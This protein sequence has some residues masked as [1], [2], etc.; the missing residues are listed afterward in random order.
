MGHR[1]LG[2][3]P[4]TR[5]WT[6]VVDLLKL[7]GDPSTI[8]S[9]T[10]KAAERGLQLTAQDSGVADVLYCLMTVVWAARRKDKF[11]KDVAQIG[12]DL[13]PTSSLLDVVAEF[14]HALD[15]RLRR[16]GHRTDLA[17]MARSAAVD[18]L[19]ETARYKAGSL[20][21][22]SLEDTRESLKSFATPS[23][24]GMIGQQFF[25]RFLYR[26]LDY[27]LSRELP[28]HIGP[29][30]QWG[31]VDECAGF[32]EA[33]ALHCHESARIVR[34]FVGCWPSAKEFKGGLTTEEVKSQFLPVALKKVQS[35]LK[36]R[37]MMHA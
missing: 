37:G 29:G 36:Q 30:K 5:N 8:A 13:H 34:E 27:H 31:S 3:L 12:L 23:K 32:K 18:A 17:E 20:F 6:K 21:G 11:K 16:Q 1:L 28:N 2:Q 14:D 26:F 7:T 15:A 33:L 25:G 10:S 19:T 4:A 9:A 35:E 22:A 24:F